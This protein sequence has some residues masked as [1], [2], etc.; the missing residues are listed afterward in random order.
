[1]GDMVV[2]RD[3]DEP[4]YNFAVVID[5]ALGGITHVIRGEDLISSTPIQILISKALGFDVPKFAHLPMILNPDRS[6][7]S[8]RFADTALADYIEEG[9]LKE[10]LI[11]FLAF[12]GWHPKE[13][14][15]VMG[16]SEIIEEFDL[17]RVQK[18]GAVFNIDKLNWLNSNYIKEVD[19][20]VFI[21]MANE[22]LP[23][24]WKLTEAMVNSVRTRVDKLSEVKELVDFYF[25][26][27]DYG[28][29]LLRWKKN[30]LKDAAQHLKEGLDM[31][32]G[33]PSDKFTIEHLEKEILD[34]IPKERRGDTLWPI[35]VALS[36]KEASPGP[37][38]IMEALGKEESERRI[39]A[40][41]QK[42]GMLSI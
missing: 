28:V 8:K 25:E 39:N 36:G 29:D 21:E 15:E 22:Y 37:F 34:K 23:D 16:I 41:I 24:D 17:G 9:Y 33:V 6:K 30:S 38:E 7:M 31:I 35:R 19:P 4:L 2:A 14:K 18:G 40:A 5:D 27:P 11:N 42:T 26:L 1:M 13:D 3:I 10:A 12:L 32:S 20:S